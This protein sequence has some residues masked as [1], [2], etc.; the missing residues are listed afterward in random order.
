MS[1]VVEVEF[2]ILRLDMCLM[3]IREVWVICRFI[4]YRY[5]DIDFIGYYF[6]GIIRGVS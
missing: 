4:N 6:L 3:R 1:F 2:F 5:V